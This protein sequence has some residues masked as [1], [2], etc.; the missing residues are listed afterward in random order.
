MPE[1]PQVS[2]IAAALSPDFAEVVFHSECDS[3]KVLNEAL[4]KMSLENVART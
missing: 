2:E 1:Q 3:R 4:A